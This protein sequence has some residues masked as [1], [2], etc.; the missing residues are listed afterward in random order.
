MFNMVQQR[1]HNAMQAIEK[2]PKLGA[3]NADYREYERACE[4]AWLRADG[5]ILRE[6]RTEKGEDLTLAEIAKIF[7]DDAN[8]DGGDESCGDDSCPCYERG[9]ERGHD[10][11][12]A[13]TKSEAIAAVESI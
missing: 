6:A 9:H 13:E 1:R 10:D 3:T 2:P 5:D 7:G 11:G 12:Y 8:G 4:I